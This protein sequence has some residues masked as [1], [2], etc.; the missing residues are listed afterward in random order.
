VISANFLA[1]FLSFS[2]SKNIKRPE[3]LKPKKKIRRTLRK[4][5]G[6][7]E[8]NL[9][10]SNH[11]I[12]WKK[13]VFIVLF[14]RISSTLWIPGEGSRFRTPQVVLKLENTGAERRCV[15]V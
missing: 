14:Q 9:K 5:F 2:H 4:N 12:F 8:K 13:L 1:W 15:T 7:K 6:D 11:N 10:I 3:M